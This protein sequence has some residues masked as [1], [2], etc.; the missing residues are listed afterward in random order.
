MIASIFFITLST[1]SYFCPDV[2]NRAG[3]VNRNFAGIFA[4]VVF[5]QPAHAN[6]VAG[7]QRQPFD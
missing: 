5:A 3:S 2:S 7:R 4:A 6:T 1:G